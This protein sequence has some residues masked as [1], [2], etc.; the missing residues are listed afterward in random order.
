[1][2]SEA[3]GT[4]LHPLR[5]VPA[6]PGVAVVL[7]FCFALHAAIDARRL[8]KMRVDRVRD[9]MK[10][11][12]VLDVEL[13][14]AASRIHPSHGCESE[15]IGRWRD[16]AFPVRVMRITH[17]H[18]T[19]IGIMQPEKSM[20]SARV[21]GHR[22]GWAQTDARSRVGDVAFAWTGT[23]MRHLDIFA[24]IRTRCSLV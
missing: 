17:S 15:S 9:P 6:D 19:P 16:F 24:V 4:S 20:S 18:L 23:I 3:E 10:R 7:P 21:C 14:L 13:P 12:L 2:R 22:E 1:L 11:I 5:D 8:A